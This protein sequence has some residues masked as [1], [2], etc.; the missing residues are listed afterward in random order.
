MT[1]SITPMA[2]R[3]TTGARLNIRLGEPSTAAPIALKVEAA[4][5]LNVR[6]LAKGET[7]RGNADWYAGDGET[8][9]W[10][11]ACSAFQALNNGVGAPASF[12]VH[13][14]ANGT[15][16]VLSDA[17]IRKVFGEVQYSEAAKKGAVNL[18]PGWAAA[19]LTEIETD[20]L[21]PIGHRKITVHKKAAE[22]FLKVFASIRD[23]GLAD[24]ILTYAGTFVPRHKGW[25]PARGLS[26]HTWAIAID[27]NAEWNGYGSAPAG[28][29]QHGSVRELVPL[30]EAQGF[31]WGGYFQPDSLRDGM[32][33]ELARYDL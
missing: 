31:G 6:G 22:P 29:G 17:E 16:A 20:V 7:V 10:S 25:N 4:T 23:A 1:I 11:G 32:H 14:R 9:F 33:F 5:P 26:A 19:N 15:I 2:G 24:R 28:L 18:A 30:F 8:F 21:E 27:L 12:A 13:R 3:V